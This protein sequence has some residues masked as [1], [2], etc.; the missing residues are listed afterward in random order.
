MTRKSKLMSVFIVYS[1]K[2]CKFHNRGNDLVTAMK[3]Q[4][5]TK[6]MLYITYVICYIR[7]KNSQVLE[8]NRKKASKLFL[9]KNAINE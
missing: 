1:G 2:L 3:V 6:S 4:L 9:K 7:G 8:K 5:T